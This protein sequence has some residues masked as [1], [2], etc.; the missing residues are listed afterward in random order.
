M[1][2]LTNA[3]MVAGYLSAL[4]RTYRSL[5]RTGQPP[6]LKTSTA[7]NGQ[8]VV[9]VGRCMCPACCA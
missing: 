7:A 4:I 2:L 8:A 5:A 1:E 3:M 9:K 6:K